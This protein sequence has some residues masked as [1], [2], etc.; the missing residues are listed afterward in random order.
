MASLLLHEINA[1]KRS[2]GSRNKFEFDERLGIFRL[3]GALPLGSVF[4]FD[5]GYIPSTQG[6]DGD[7]LDVLILM[8]EP[9]FTGQV[10]FWEPNRSLN[11]L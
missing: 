9:A 3:G 10:S 6:G 8:D 5:F 2:E 1:A 7:P 11:R 4:P